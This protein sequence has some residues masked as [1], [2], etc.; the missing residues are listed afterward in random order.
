MRRLMVREVEL[1]QVG[2]AEFLLTADF[3]EGMLGYLPS[4][5]PDDTGLTDPKAFPSSSETG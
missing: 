4:L 2:G 5:T 1:P 3:T